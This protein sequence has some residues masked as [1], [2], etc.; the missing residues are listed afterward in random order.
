MK[1]EL[2]TAPPPVP[3]Y[4]LH[5]RV[6]LSY[7]IAPGGLGGGPRCDSNCGRTW[8]RRGPGVAQAWPR[9][10]PGVAQVWPRCASMAFAAT[11]RRFSLASALHW[12]DTSRRELI[13][14]Q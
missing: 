6:L 8:A 2:G 4:A 11:G 12:S 1:L 14:A 7:R 3:G 9:R 10:G 5:R 13:V